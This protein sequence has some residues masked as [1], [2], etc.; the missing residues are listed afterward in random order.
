MRAPAIATAQKWSGSILA[1]LGLFGIAV[2]A[3]LPALRESP[4]S[5][6]VLL[7]MLAPARV[8]PQ[9]GLGVAFGLVSAR[10]A[11][12]AMVLFGLGIISGFVAEDLLLR[13]LDTVPRAAT[14]LF[15][16]GPISYLAVGGALAFS[17]RLRS[18]AVP[19][20]AT[21]FGAMLALVI[22]MTDPSLHDAAY[23]WTPVLVACWIIVAVALT[24][25]AFR[26]GWFLIFSRILGSWLLA[27]GILYGGASLIPKRERPPPPAIEVP[28][29]PKPAPVPRVDPASPK[30]P[31]P[32]QPGPSIG[33]GGDDRFRQP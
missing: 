15:L 2:I 16:T 29:S 7:E 19:I 25:R 22:K 5:R 9:I 13:I 10:V 20:A 12:A 27:I 6:W 24:V 14:H 1:G 30:L 21:I 4:L 11:Y 28:V 23:T 31:V 8:L 33:P 32:D 26:R 17:P 3:L 18:F